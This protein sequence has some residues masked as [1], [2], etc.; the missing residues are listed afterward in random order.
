LKKCLQKES[1]FV[2]FDFQFNLE[3]MA[4]E[5]RSLLDGGFKKVKKL[6]SEEEGFFKNFQMTL[7]STLSCIDFCFHSLLLRNYYFY[8]ILLFL[9]YLI[10]II[11][12]IIFMLS[13][14]YYYY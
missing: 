10:I 8:V 14:Y 11:I 9:C 6:R 7:D 2:E 1:T 12:I 13:Y 3:E 4:M 5:I